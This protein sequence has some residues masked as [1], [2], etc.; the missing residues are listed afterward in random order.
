MVKK[1]D[2]YCVAHFGED[3]SFWTKMFHTV[4]GV[5][6]FV[7]LG[8]TVTDYFELTF[9]KKS[10]SEKKKYMTFRDSNRFAKAFDDL[11]EGWTLSKKTELMTWLGKYLCREQISAQDMRLEDFQAFTQRHPVFLFKPSTGSCGIGIEK[12]DASVTP[13]EDLFSRYAG[14]D[15]VLDECIL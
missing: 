8:S 13:A 4:K 14:Q 10:F 2:E 5:A 11:D 1:F 12:A 9:Y 6:D 3:V 15:G 7:L